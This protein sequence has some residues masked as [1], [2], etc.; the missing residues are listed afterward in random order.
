MDVPSLSAQKPKDPNPS[1]WHPAHTLQ[2]APSNFIVAKAMHFFQ[3][4]CQDGGII[5]SQLK[6]RSNQLQAATWHKKTAAQ[7]AGVW[8]IN[9][10]RKG[11]C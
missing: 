3:L 10:Q 6:G 1:V 2:D 7:L 11:R 5:L 9:E 4:S 8:L